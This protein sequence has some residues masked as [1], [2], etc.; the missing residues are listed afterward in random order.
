MTRPATQIEVKSPSQ[1]SFSSHFPANPNTTNNDKQSP[2]KTQ[3]VGGETDSTEKPQTG[4]LS[5]TKPKW[6]ILGSE[7]GLAAKGSR[8]L[9][10][11]LAE[12]V[13][14]VSW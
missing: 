10:A 2:D 8:R 12:A 13:S 9:A 4:R 6:P 3:A 1:L 7:F 14:N 5:L 11:A